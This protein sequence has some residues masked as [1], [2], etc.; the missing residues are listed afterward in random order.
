MSP[1]PGFL[2]VVRATISAR[3][4][5]SSRRFRLTFF[6][7]PVTL[8]LKSF[9]ASPVGRLGLACSLPFTAGKGKERWTSMKL[10]SLLSALLVLGG[11]SLAVRLLTQGVE[12]ALAATA[13]EW[14]ARR[15]KVLYR[16]RA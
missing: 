16:Q 12:L 5:S 13:M 3:A 9:T 2:F 7:R 10:E 15:I 4:D 11:T 14:F 6:L 8:G 1:I